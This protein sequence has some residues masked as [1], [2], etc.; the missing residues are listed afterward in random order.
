MFVGYKIKLSVLIAT[1]AFSGQVL[2][3]ASF[4]DE[5]DSESAPAQ[6]AVPAPA[7]TAPAGR[8][9]PNTPKPAAYSSPFQCS[10]NKYTSDASAAREMIEKVTGI[11]SALSKT[12]IDDS[13]QNSFDL[14][15]GPAGDLQIRAVVE[16]SAYDLAGFVC[17]APTGLIVKLVH[18]MQTNF[19]KVRPINSRSVEIR[20]Y[21][22]GKEQ[23]DGSV[24]TSQS[25]A[26]R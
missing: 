10:Q 9:V 6:A 16:G 7:A 25:R 3:Q 18:P 13:G 8:L 23:N 4:L 1:L 14:K 12:L 26:T 19:V 24:F 20:K 22:G 17:Q 21:V 15:H 11:S 2:A 5:D